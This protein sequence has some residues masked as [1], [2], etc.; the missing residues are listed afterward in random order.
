MLNQ[1]SHPGAL[2]YFFFNFLMFIF[3]RERE[4]ASEQVE[5]GEGQREREPENP[6]QSSGSE[7][8]AQSLTRDL[9]SWTMRS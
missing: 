3:E 4:R 5:A 9:N 2:I 7:L 1:L 6:K 8:S